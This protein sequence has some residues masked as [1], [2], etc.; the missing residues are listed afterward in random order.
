MTETKPFWKSW[1]LWSLLLVIAPIVSSIIGFDLVP[2]FQDKAITG[3]EI[4]QI[5]GALWAMYNRIVATKQL[6]VKEI[7]NT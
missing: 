3:D 2:V 6:T 4:I 7:P 1:T 5:I